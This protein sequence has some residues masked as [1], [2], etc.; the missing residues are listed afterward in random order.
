MTAVTSSPGSSPASG[1]TT[2]GVRSGTAARRRPGLTLFTVASAACGLA[3]TAGAL[4]VA[5]LVQ[6]AAAAVLVPSSLAL[7]Q[8]AHPDP[9]AQARAVGV[10]G[11][12]AGIA[13]AFGPV[14][15]GVLTDAA[16]WRLVFFVN[17]PIGVAALLLTVR[18]VVR[19]EGHGRRGLDRRRPRR[20]PRWAC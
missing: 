6:R 11:G 7:L 8:A 13:A 3:P 5:R 19:P 18:Y 16:S 12:V 4:V 17:V 20:W 9:R 1:S 15:G 10:W 2:C 14:V